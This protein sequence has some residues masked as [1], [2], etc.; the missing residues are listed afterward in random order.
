MDNVGANTDQGTATIFTQSTAT[1]HV[2]GVAPRYQPEGGRNRV[3]TQVTIRDAGNLPVSGATV[4]LDVTAPNGKHRALQGTTDANGKTRVSVVT[5]LHGTFTFCV[6][7][8][9]KTG[10]TYDPTQNVETCDSIIVP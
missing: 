10:Y 9:T 1:L 4:A 5:S 8:V 6:T 3:G 7:D 2:A